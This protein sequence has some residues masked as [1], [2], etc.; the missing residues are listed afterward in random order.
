MS[1]N[2]GQIPSN[3]DGADEA[4]TLDEEFDAGLAEFTEDAGAPALVAAAPA[5]EVV[6]DQPADVT[7]A[8]APA[9]APK[10]L[11]AGD[12]PPAGQTPTNDIWANATPELRE[13]H[14]A[15][16]RDEKLRTETI[17]G[18]QSA[19]DRKIAELTA[20]LARA[21]QGDQ[22]GS[23]QQPGATEP[24]QE[25]LADDAALKQLR[26]DYPEVAGPLLD[27]IAKQNEQLAKLTPAVTAFE[28]QQK[29][30]AISEQENLLT[31][32]HSDWADAATDDRFGGWLE[33]QPR[34]I[35]E[36]MQRNFS[37]IVDGAEAALVIGKFKADVGFAK[38]PAPTPTPT[39]TPAEQRRQRQLA[40]GRDAGGNGPAMTAG[41]PDD[42]D[43]ATDVFLSK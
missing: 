19:A 20:Q 37:A 43:A 11:A 39:P 1:G 35:K 33:S 41:I 28:T 6:I 24:K 23:P 18:R 3:S 4:L 30:A 34:A 32:E 40:N 7:P 16:I 10:D 2:S 38:A 22:G 17:K 5:S 26:E 8:P 21:G 12:E 29:S 15:A 31:K 42:F 13:A 9:A 14:E 25:V 36:A 27:L